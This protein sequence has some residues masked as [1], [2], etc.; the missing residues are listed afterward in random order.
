MK[1]KLRPLLDLKTALDQMKA[2]WPASK[3]SLAQVR[4]PCIRPNCKACAKGT[5]HPVYIFAYSQ[6]GI[7][8]CKYVPAAMVPVLEKAL[9]NGRR[10][11]ELLTAT[12]PALLE[13]YRA[14]NP[15]KTGPKIR[16]PTKPTAKS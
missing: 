10:L 15:A 5:K 2:L 13:D 16:K 14:K 3:G 8:A 12:G 11:E 7:R 1:K 6:N 9:E 4:R